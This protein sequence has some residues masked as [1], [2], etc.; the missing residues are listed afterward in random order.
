MTRSSSWATTTSDAL[1]IINAEF[2]RTQLLSCK[3]KL[4]NHNIMTTEV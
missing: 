3:F 4:I 2:Q 1:L